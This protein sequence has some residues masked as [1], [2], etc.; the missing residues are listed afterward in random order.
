MRKRDWDEALA[1]HQ[2][3]QVMPHSLAQVV[4]ETFLLPL[5]S[6]RYL[7]DA[8]H[9]VSEGTCGLGYCPCL[10]FIKINANSGSGALYGSGRS[11]RLLQWVVHV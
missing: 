2:V 4:A 9:V 8:D 6:A 7:L 10:M 11:A 3:Q 1:C 5:H